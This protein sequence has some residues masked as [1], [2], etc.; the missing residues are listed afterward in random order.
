MKMENKYYTPEIEDLFIG[1]ECEMQWSCGYD[2]TWEPYVF[3]ITDED[4]VYINV[5][6][7]FDMLDDGASAARTKYLDKEDIEKCGWMTSNMIPVWIENE[8]V[9]KRID[10]YEFTIHEELW[11][12]LVNIEDNVW[13]IQKR[14]YRNSVGQSCEQLFKGECKSINELRKIMKIIG[15][16]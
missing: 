12:D 11:Y 2:P 9:E 10:G 13:V 4:G 15:I 8:D 6:F 1:Y 7:T 3:K 5:G 16:K 14:W